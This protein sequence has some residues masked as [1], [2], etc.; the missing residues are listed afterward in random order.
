MNKTVYI[1]LYTLSVG[2]AERH[3]SSIANYLVQHGYKVEFVLLQDNI[4]DYSLE[5][6]VNVTSLVELSYPDK[7]RNNKLSF[8]DRI[9][10]KLLQVTSNTKYKYFDK[11]LYIKALYLKK[12]DYWFSQQKNMNQSTVIS[13]M[14]VPNIISAELKRKYG[15]NLILG[16]FTSPQLEFPS[17][18]PENKMK[19][20]YF[21]DANG[22]VLQTYEQEEFYTYLSNVKKK[23]IPNPIE[24]IGIVP[25]RGTRKKEIVN[26]CKH[27]K[28]KNLPLLI[29]AFAKLLREYPDY[30]LV[31]Y[32]DGPERKNIEKCIANYGVAESVCLQPYAKN[33]L[34]LVRESA[35][36]VSSSDREG[37][38]NSM[39]EAMAIGLPTICTD[40][41]AGGAKMFIEPYKNGI[42]VPVR[43]P[44]S[45]YKAMKYM[46]DHPEEADF[47]SLNAVAIRQTL[48]K[49]KILSQWLDFLKDVQGE[50]YGRNYD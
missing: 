49:N 28:A 2:G 33:V 43:D 27:V 36:F 50:T 41:P 21:P 8:V 20:K 32:G 5:T 9:F 22:L 30:K 42:I 48:K 44:D 25:F 7:I 11:K 17:D 34:E 16:E 18:A 19:K 14:T 37:I 15:Y 26:Y 23:V 46:I 3:A 29:E 10:L 39:L 12:L 4:V 6:E 35:M 1:V 24:E 47:M 40:C 38:S 13:F 45:L 31:I